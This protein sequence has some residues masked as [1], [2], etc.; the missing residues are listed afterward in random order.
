M[1]SAQ[2][3][4]SVKIERKGFLGSIFGSEPSVKVDELS[5]FTRQFATLL[6]A[7]VPLTRSFDCFRTPHNVLHKVMHEV[8]IKVES[9]FRL[10]AAMRGYP[11]VF[12]AIYVALVE[13]GET[14][15]KLVIVLQKLADDMEKQVRIKKRLI[16]ALTYPAVL[17]CAA[18]VC[19][20]F[21][22]SYILPMLE[23]MFKSTNIP[24]PGPTRV[25]LQMH[26]IIPGVIMAG[27]IFCILAWFGHDRLK[28]YP[29]R[30]RRLHN[31]LLHVPLFGSL[32]RSMAVTRILQSLS[33]MLDVGLN[34]VPA[35]KCC[36]SLTSNTHISHELSQVRLRLIDGETLTEA[37]QQGN[38]FPKAVVHI[39]AAGEETSDL[40]PMIKFGARLLEEDADLLIESMA[41]SLEPVIMIIM[42]V[43][44][45]FIVL[46]A[47]LPIVQLIQ[48][49]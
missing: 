36:E 15:G 17:M 12:N 23:P 25:L 27:V 20:M 29:Q 11:K 26:Y 16:S 5:I 14:T 37:L 41:Q 1:A 40:I 2:K 19:V 47:M 21:F 28:R 31:L 46:A 30:I 35:L 13:S 38:L 45:G 6:G 48:N 42:G 8:G 3:G 24:L 34:L 44:V 32:Y 9:G 4:S 10:S 22:F 39:V 43:V 18:F 33:S 49:L 7:G